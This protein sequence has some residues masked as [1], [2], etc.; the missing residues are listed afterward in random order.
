MKKLQWFTNKNL[1]AE[2]KSRLGLRIR[3]AI[4][5][6]RPNILGVRRFN[7]FLGETFIWSM[8]KLVHEP[9]GSTVFEI[10]V[11]LK[12]KKEN[13]EFI[14]AIPAPQNYHRHFNSHYLI[15]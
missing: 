5:V 6:T 15:R 8:N 3:P 13:A 14:A 2:Q 1:V 11:S 9:R 4:P 7:T 12:V 10:W